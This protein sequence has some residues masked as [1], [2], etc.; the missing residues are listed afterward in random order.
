MKVLEKATIKTGEKIQIEDWSD[1]YTFHRFAD[2]LVAF[3]KTRTGRLFRAELQFENA[4]KA[5][6]AFYA[7][8]NGEKS[9]DDFPFTAK[10]SGKDVPFR[11]Y[12]PLVERYS[13]TW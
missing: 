8:T 5:R 9:L 3:P 11:Q 6:E 12:V 7:L 13:V 4:T 2:L 1:D 10:S